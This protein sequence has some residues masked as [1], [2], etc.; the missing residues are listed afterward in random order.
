MKKAISNMI[1]SVSSALDFN[2]ATLSGCVDII[3]VPQRD[4]TFKSTPFHVR[5]GKLKVLKSADKIV[6]IK[7]NNREVGFTMKLG[8]AGE[9]YFEREIIKPF[10]NS[11]ETSDLKFI[12]I[13]DDLQKEV[14][15]EQAPQGGNIDALKKSQQK[16]HIKEESKEEEKSNLRDILEIN[17][18]DK[19]QTSA[20]T[21]D[22]C[23]EDYENNFDPIEEIEKELNKENPDI[24]IDKEKLKHQLEGP[25]ANSSKSNSPNK[26]RSST[27]SPPKK[28]T[29]IRDGK[30]VVIKIK[31]TLRPTSDMLKTLN[32]KPGSNIITYTV[33]T[34]FQGEQTLTGHIYLWPLDAKVIV[35]D[36]D[37][38]ITKSDFL[39]Q[40]MPIIGRDWSQPG[41][42]PLY[43]NIRRNGYYIMYLTSRA[44][45]QSKL[46]KDFI[47]S[48]Y[49]DGKMMPHGPVVMSPDRIMSSLKREVVFK[50]PELFKIATLR[51]IKKL[52]PYDH[53]P[54]FAGFGNRETDAIAYTAVGMS[55]NNIFT[56][57]PKGT[58]SHINDYVSSYAMLNSK[59]KECFPFISSIKGHLKHIKVQI[60][61]S[62]GKYEKESKE[63][64]QDETNLSPIRVLT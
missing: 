63:D 23:Q 32:L 38:T 5:F 1:N 31:R 49:Q 36:V 55:I 4:G 50:R 57:D 51:D 6:E 25:S 30:P 42:A 17:N 40:I 15:E 64:N 24:E 61:E 35:S 47:F 26:R 41:I 53:S 19:V 59:V 28:R 52:F 37:G 39:G 48:V 7:V 18:K 13:D 9:G 34:R 56:V 12:A 58:L 21:Q 2:E 54:F 27:A 11:K 3:V 45:G 20:Q 44:I 62:V 10:S 14:F 43:C 16:S 22:Q 33:N 46:T 60:D 29:E 8:E